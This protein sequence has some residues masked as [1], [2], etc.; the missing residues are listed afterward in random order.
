MTRFEIGARRLGE[1]WM[2]VQPELDLNLPA[3]Q[4]E[5]MLLKTESHCATT[6]SAGGR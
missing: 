2:D 3:I 1:S 5:V 6:S 4:A